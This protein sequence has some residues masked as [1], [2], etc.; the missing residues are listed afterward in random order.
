[1]A[2]R[3][4][5]SSRKLPSGRWQA[6]YYGPDGVRR[7][8]PMT[9]RTK[10]DAERWLTLKEAEIAKGEWVNPDAGKVTVAEWGNRWLDSVRPSLKPKTHASYVSLFRTQIEPRFGAMA[11]AA[12]RPISVSEWGADM[13]S[14]GLSAS[15][16]RQAHVVLAL[17]MEAAVTN[18]LIRVSPCIGTKLPRLVVRDPVI[19]TRDQVEK[20]VKAAA[21]PHDLLI[22][23]M[24]Y[25]GLR[26][27]EA[28][29]LRRKSIDLDAGAIRVTETLV[30]IS[31]KTSFGTPKSHQVRDV[32]LPAFLL[33]R[34]RAHLDEMADKSPDALLFVNKRGNPLHYNAW[35]TWKFDP[36]AEKAGLDGVT[37][38]DLRATHASWVA[39]AFG[40][41]AAGRR[42]GHSNTTITTRHYARRLEGKDNEVARGLDAFRDGKIGLGARSGHDQ[43]DDAPPGAMSS[44]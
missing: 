19:L 10:K 24:A 38:H 36:A 29:A 13:H 4:F 43:D 8:A 30:E 33:R 28:F 5:G 25:A 40:V 39:D 7:N 22:E 23:I 27:G 32:Q 9:F 14:R 37:P 1:M 17:M 41:L 31:G 2:R 16:I 42:L 20:L 44:A 3:R 21:P 12:V 35:R 6:R 11:L 15:R 34:L 18:E 26:V